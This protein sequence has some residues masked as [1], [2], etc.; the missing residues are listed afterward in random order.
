MADEA[1]RA[2]VSNETFLEARIAECRGKSQQ[3]E[4]AEECEECGEPIPLKR[5]EA[6]PGCLYCVA[7][8][9]EYEADI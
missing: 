2:Q 3:G 4:G 8:Q 7:C 6:V 5:R 1:D 9:A